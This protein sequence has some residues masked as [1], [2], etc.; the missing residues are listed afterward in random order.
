LEV[1]IQRRGDTSADIRQYQA[2]P[3]DTTTEHNT[4]DRKHQS[5][6][7]RELPKITTDDGL[8]VVLLRQ[9]G[10]CTSPPFVDRKTTGQT[11]QTVAVK[12]ANALESI[13]CSATNGN[14]PHLWMHD[15]IFPPIA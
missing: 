5:H 15:P 11:F 3:S 6:R 9:F 10:Q 4:I 12:W 2:A 14:V 13:A 7:R 8:S 1:A